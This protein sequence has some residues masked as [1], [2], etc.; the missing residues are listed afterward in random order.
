MFFRQERR[1]DEKYLTSFYQYVCIRMGYLF[2]RYIIVL[3][4]K[5]IRLDYIKLESKA[6]SWHAHTFALQKKEKE[7]IK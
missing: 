4:M 3:H 2:Y 6:R 7:I 5:D 1:A